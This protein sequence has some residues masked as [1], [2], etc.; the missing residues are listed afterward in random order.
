M[1]YCEN[2]MNKLYITGLSFSVAILLAILFLIVSP[3]NPDNSG[4]TKSSADSNS[5]LTIEDKNQIITITASGGYFP[6]LVNAKA[7]TPTKLKVVTKNTYD[8]SLALYIPDLD[9]SKTLPTT[10][11]T[12]VNIPPQPAGKKLKGMCS[13]GMYRFNINFN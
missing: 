7:N 2:T 1:W 8:C 6:N 10:G 3:N 13:M 11:I 9:Y 12:E 5:A 4:N